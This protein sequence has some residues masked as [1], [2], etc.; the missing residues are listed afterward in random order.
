MRNL[1]VGWQNAYRQVEG[2]VEN[3]LKEKEDLRKD[4][5]EQIQKAKQVCMESLSGEEIFRHIK[6]RLLVVL[7]S[8]HG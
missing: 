6:L 8:H 5:V 3:T 2:S 7:E 1:L 4:C